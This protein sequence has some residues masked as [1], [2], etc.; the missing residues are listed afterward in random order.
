MMMR[1]PPGVLHDHALG[2]PQR[3]Q[4]YSSRPH[5]SRP[6]SAGRVGQNHNHGYYMFNND[7][8]VRPQSAAPTRNRWLA[9]QHG[10]NGSQSAR[11]RTAPTTSGQAA[12]NRREKDESFSALT[13]LQNMFNK[14]YNENQV[15]ILKRKEAEDNLREFLTTKEGHQ[16]K[17]IFEQRDLVKS[18]RNRL[19]NMEQDNVR[20]TSKAKRCERRAYEEEMFLK[21]AL[22]EI[23]TLRQVTVELQ[24]MN[25]E[26]HESPQMK[27]IEQ[28][29]YKFQK[30]LTKRTKELN[31]QNDL[32]EKAVEE[33][34]MRVEKVNTKVDGLYEMTEAVH[35]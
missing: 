9:T 16:A 20:A 27:L 26:L 23:E 4:L 18:L 3:G 33:I 10:G 35:S 14:V 6:H 25:L 2:S 1:S 5:S 8:G 34:W 11:P 31:D 7:A 17:Q 15:L 21:Q 13:N 29:L 12:L 28:K 24:R 30:G 32:Q 22:K 19:Y